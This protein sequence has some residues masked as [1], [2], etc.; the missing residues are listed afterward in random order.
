MSKSKYTTRYEKTR[1]ISARA[2]QLSQGSPP[3]MNIPKNVKDPLEIA[4][5]EWKEGLIPIDIKTRDRIEKK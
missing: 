1:I 3:M 2:L 4:T 5:L